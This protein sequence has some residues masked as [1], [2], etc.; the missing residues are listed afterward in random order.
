MTNETQTKKRGPKSLLDPTQKDKLMK[1]LRNIR[2][3]SED[4]PVLATMR[5]LVDAG[6]LVETI[7]AVEGRG[8]G[9][10]AIKFELTGAAK[11]KVTNYFKRQEKTVG[12]EA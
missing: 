7:P 9:R 10:P 11:S 3:N 1:T 5:K 12:Q 2:E 6:L 4:V 8:R